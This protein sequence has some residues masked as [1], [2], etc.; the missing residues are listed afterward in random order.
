[1]NSLAF[2]MHFGW[3]YWEDRDTLGHFASLLSEH[4]STSIQSADLH[5]G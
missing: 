1:M 4:L 2:F 3:W 5:L